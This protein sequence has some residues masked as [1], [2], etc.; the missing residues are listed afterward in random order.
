MAISFLVALLSSVSPNA[1]KPTILPSQSTPVQSPFDA[2]VLSAL[3]EIKSVLFDLRSK[4]VPTVPRL[5]P[6]IASE[7]KPIYA[8]LEAAE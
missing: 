7:A 6:R 3:A 2:E 1:K 4:G 5:S 8:P